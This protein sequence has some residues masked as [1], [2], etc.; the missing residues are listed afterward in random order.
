MHLIKKNNMCVCMLHV[1]VPYLY[2]LYMLLHNDELHRHGR[3]RSVIHQRDIAL[4]AQHF[5][6][7]RSTSGPQCCSAVS[8]PSSTDLRWLMFGA[9]CDGRVLVR[10]FYFWHNLNAWNNLIINTVKLV[11]RLFALPVF[12]FLTPLLSSG[13]RWDRPSGK[14]LRTNNTFGSLMSIKSFL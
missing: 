13:S 1:G 9:Q 10:Y 4:T 14:S 8:L 7:T 6:S 11:A 12:I 2:I 5:R 3:V